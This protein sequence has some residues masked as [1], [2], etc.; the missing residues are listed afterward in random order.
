MGTKRKG[1]KAKEFEWMDSEEDDEGVTRP[2]DS[3][4]AAPSSPPMLVPI[5]KVDTLAQMVRLAPSLEKRLRSGDVRSRE[6]CDIAEALARSK[7]FDPGLFEPLAAELRRAFQRGRLGG[8]DVVH[9]LLALADLNAYDATTFE[10]ACE[11]LRPDLGNVPEASRQ[12]LET[13]FKKLSHNPGE[14]FFA[15]LK[16][17]RRDRREACPMF[18]RGQCKWG[19]K[20]KLSHDQESF[21]A[22]AKEGA[23][24]PPSQSGGKSVGFQQSSDLFKADRCGALW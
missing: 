3:P 23:W 22:T 17:C 21:E 24:K 19:P 9:I 20:C 1:K 6:L 14:E 8:T 2:H 16:I 12:R 4:R 15:A 18:W 11:A 5:D 10:A 7:F 13:A